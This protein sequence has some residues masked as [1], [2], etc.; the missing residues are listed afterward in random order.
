LR[1]LTGS[2]DLSDFRG[3]VRRAPWMV[4][5]LAVCLLS[6]LGIP[7]LV[8]FAA[9]FQ[10]FRVLYDESQ[11]YYGAGQPGL[12]ATL[13]G[14]LLIGGLNTVISAVYYINVLRVMI[15]EPR[16][17]DLEGKEPVALPEP[18]SAIFFAVLVS[19]VIVVLGILWDPLDKASHSGAE[20][21]LKNPLAERPQVR[22][23]AGA[24]G[25]PGGLVPGPGRGGLQ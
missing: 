3:L 20:R 9:K 22:L 10:I 7:P 16:A 1:R 5:T 21:F 13:F 12:G 14:L 24:V 8:G 23:P 17:E 15:L 25:G 11:F 4:V 6:L 19:L 2:E 18:F